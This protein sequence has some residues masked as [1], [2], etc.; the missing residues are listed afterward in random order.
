MY[1]VE[2]WKKTC[3]WTSIWKYSRLRA[4][5]FWT[6]GTRRQSANDIWLG[7]KGNKMKGDEKGKSMKNVRKLAMM[8]CK[9]VKLELWEFEKRKITYCIRS[10]LVQKVRSTTNIWTKLLVAFSCTSLNKWILSTIRPDVRSQ[11]YVPKM[12]W[13]QGSSLSSACSAA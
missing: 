5:L 1:T 7:K 2:I 8:Q 10:Y 12:A 13:F 4:H 3:L 9:M 6:P 11:K